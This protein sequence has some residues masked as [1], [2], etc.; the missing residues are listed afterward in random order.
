M[1]LDGHKTIECRI[2]RVGIPPHG[3]LDVGDLIWFKEAGGLVRLVA[4]A[5]SVRCFHPLSP[6][7]L[8]LIRDRFNEQILAPRAFWR[9]HRHAQVATLGWLGEICE[10][11]PFQVAKR[12]RRAWVVLDGPPVPSSLIPGA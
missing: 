9:M 4:V 11:K 10:L 6:H 7:E 12:D 1:I 2:G 3:Y 8:D 5:R